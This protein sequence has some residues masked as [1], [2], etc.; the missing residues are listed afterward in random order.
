MIII[1]L[2]TLI[3]TIITATAALVAIIGGFLISRVI[4]LSSE[5]TGIKRRLK[6][7]NNEVIAKEEMLNRLEQTL[8]DEDGVDFIEGNYEELAFN[9]KTIE[10]LLEAEDFRGR[11]SEELQPYYDELLNVK[12]DALSMIDVAIKNEE[13]YLDEF[14]EFIITRK[15]KYPHRKEWYKL[16]YE[17]IRIKI[18][19]KNRPKGFLSLQDYIQDIPIAPPG[20]FSIHQVQEYNQK[21]RDRDK[22]ED[23]LSTLYLQRDSQIKILEKYGNPKGHWWGLIVLVYACIVGIVYPSTLL[24]YPLDFYDDVSTKTL[25]L[26][27]FY[28][29]L[30]FL[31]T[32][33]GI[34]IFILTKEEENK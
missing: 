33:L 17:L 3:S 26:S 12:E 30:L 24:P 22:L 19:R 20:T 25:L 2:N 21:V 9:R 5:Q 1:D 13:N 23:D 4:T 15:M 28:S 31:F 18:I 8:L 32:Y 7:I 34:Y 10:D 14:D 6:E 16:I 11:T 29:Q 27:L